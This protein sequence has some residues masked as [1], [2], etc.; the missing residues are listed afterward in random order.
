MVCYKAVDKTRGLELKGRVEEG[1]GYLIP[2]P[3]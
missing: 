1:G 3:V 2:W